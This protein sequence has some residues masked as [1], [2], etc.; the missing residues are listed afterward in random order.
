MLTNLIWLNQFVEYIKFYTLKPLISIIHILKNNE[1][2]YVFRYGY[3][4]SCLDK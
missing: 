4:P 2:K 1:N 3:T